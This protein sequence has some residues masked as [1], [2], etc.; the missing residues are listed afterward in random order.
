MTSQHWNFCG[1]TEQFRCKGNKKSP[2]R[3]HKAFI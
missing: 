2:V 3:M 1:Q